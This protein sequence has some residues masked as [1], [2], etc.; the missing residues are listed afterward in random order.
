MY[1]V[2]SSSKR[3]SPYFPIC[4]LFISFPCLIALPEA[5]SILLNK[6]GASRDSLTLFVIS[7]EEFS[8]FHHGFWCSLMLFVRLRKFLSQSCWIFLSK[9]RYW[10]NVLKTIVAFIKYFLPQIN[11]LDKVIFKIFRTYTLPKKSF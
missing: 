1:K 6:R 4:L 9:A 7:T 5:C 2:M 10:T 11:I 3:G 8:V